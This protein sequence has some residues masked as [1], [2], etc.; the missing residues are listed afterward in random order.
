MALSIRLQQSKFK[1]KNRGGKWH[2]RV[3]SNGVTS[4]NDLA[5]SIQEN[6]TFTRGEV[7]GIIMALVDEI[8]YSLSLGNTVVLDGL[9][10]FHLTVESEPVENK[11]DFDIKKILRA[12]NASSFLRVVAIPPHERANRTLRRVYR[13]CGLTLTMTNDAARRCCQC[14]EMAR[15]W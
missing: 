15:A 8:S 7:T 13:W 2:A 11:E 12:S 14:F 3:V 1:E 4:T 9:G 10:R 5:E 6:T